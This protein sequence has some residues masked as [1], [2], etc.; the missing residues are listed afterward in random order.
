M[1]KNYSLII[2]PLFLYT[3]FIFFFCG[4]NQSMLNYEVQINIMQI[5]MEK[6]GELVSVIYLG[7]KECLKEILPLQ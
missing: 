7:V 1:N 3:F 2:K 4:N 6:T 5:E